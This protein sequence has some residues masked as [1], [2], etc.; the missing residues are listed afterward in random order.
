MQR[1]QQLS[2]YKPTSLQRNAILVGVNMYLNFKIMSDYRPE[3][4][5]LRILHINICT[6]AKI[7]SVL[8][9]S[10]RRKSRS[11]G[12]G[13][14]LREWRSFLLSF[15][16]SCTHFR[17]PIGIFLWPH[18]WTS[19]SSQ[20]LYIILQ[21]QTHN[22]AAVYNKT[23]TSNVL[24]S[25]QFFSYLTWLTTFSMPRQTRILA[26]MRHISQQ[27]FLLKAWYLTTLLSRRECWL[28][29]G[30]SSDLLL[31]TEQQKSSME[32]LSVTYEMHHSHWKLCSPMTSHTISLS[33]WI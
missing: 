16:H 23:I 19:F 10:F 18:I 5:I 17:A 9:I 29:R 26:A 31:R 33:S 12:S 3:V 27:E 1:G 15:V 8:W 20:I 7:S 22:T 2:G 4:T 6:L 24:V 21:T 32:L 14:F 30:Q 11:S 25:R 28:H 13:A